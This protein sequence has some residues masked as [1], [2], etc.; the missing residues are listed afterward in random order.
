MGVPHRVHGVDAL[1]QA[2]AKVAALLLRGYDLL[3][4]GPGGASLL[5]QR[6]RQRWP[7][8]RCCCR[9]LCTSKLVMCWAPWGI[10]EQAINNTG[11]SRVLR[12]PARA[13]HDMHLSKDRIGCNTSSAQ[14]FAH[15]LTMFY[16]TQHDL[17]L[18]VYAAQSKQRLARCSA[19][20][21]TAAH[22]QKYCLVNRRSQFKAVVG[23]LGAADQHQIIHG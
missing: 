21:N 6:Q 23:M 2:A 10:S 17:R 18:D 11:T 1:A 12:A 9:R 19:I 15:I 7:R 14:T 16:F 4:V 8:R 5:R 20:V 13:P 3:A 22:D